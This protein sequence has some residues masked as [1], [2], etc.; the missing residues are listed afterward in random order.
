MS[1]K[2]IIVKKS[3]RKY[4][5][6]YTILFAFMACIIYIYFI[7][8]NRSFVWHMDGLTQHLPALTYLGGWL[9]QI[10]KNIFVNHSF[11]IPM[12]D[13]SIGYGSDIITTLHY[14]AL[15]DP[16]NIFAI[17]VPA[18]K[19]E[20]LYNILI[21]VRLYLAGI[22]FS[23][24]C[25]SRGK[26]NFAILV[27][28][29]IYVFC[30]YG[31]SVSVRHPYFI[32]PMIYF[33]ILLIGIEKIFK[34]QKPYLFIIATAV[35]AI[36]NFYFFYMLA[37]LIFLYAVFRYV[38]LFKKIE[39]KE[40]LKWVM[41]FSGYFLIGSCIAMII[42]LPNAMLVVGSARY[43]AAKTI[44]LLYLEQQYYNTFLSFISAKHTS[45]YTHLNFST[46]ALVSI[47]VLFTQKKDKLA[48][49]IGLLLTTIFYLFP[50]FGFLFNGFSSSQ[51]R[52]I[53]GYAL[54][55]AFISVDMIPKFFELNKKDKK[56]IFIFTILYT[57]LYLFITS[58][59][60]V[61]CYKCVCSALGILVINVILI[62]MI[63][64]V[65]KSK[66]FIQILIL[67]ITCIGIG[68][69]AYFIFSENQENY[70][71]EFKESGKAYN[72]I[73]NSPSSLVKNIKDDSVFRYDQDKG[74]KLVYNSSVLENLFGVGYRFS[75]ADGNI[76]KFY[77][78]NFI[79]TPRDYS[80]ST[81]DN[82]TI[83]DTLA[84]VKYFI[85]KNNRTKDLPYGYK[86]LVTS[87]VANKKGYQV[88]TTDNYL[89]L[90]YT[91]ENYISKE[92][93]DSLSVTQKQ[94]AF[95]QGVVLDKKINNMK[96]SELSFTDKKVDYTITPDKN[97]K[98]IG[99]KI[100]TSKKNSTVTLNF[101]GL[102]NSETYLVLNKI[103]VSKEMISGKYKI[104]VE[105]ENENKVVELLTERERAYCGR[106]SFL[107][108]LNYN[109]KESNQ[110]K[111]TFLKQG[112]YSFEELAVVCQPMNGFEQAVKKLK[113]DTL[114]SIKID[115]N[116][117][118]GTI[119]L[120]RSKFLVLSIPYSKGW[121]V[122]VDG[123]KQEVLKANSMY[124][125]TFLEPGEHNVVFRYH[126]PY[127]KISASI[128]IMGTLAFI[129]VFIYHKKREK[130]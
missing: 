60:S 58:R 84:S 88:Y 44:P 64:N 37:I 29:I 51:N 23:I 86:K 18:A 27:G 109:Q 24:Y 122:Y 55:V 121:T 20:Y 35:S 4:F 67:G 103:G 5:I 128:S 31:M 105:G 8:K 59:L 102:K 42:F 98:I 32:N 3:A 115:T 2:D 70:V 119:T 1:N 73:M 123:K 65:L 97:T 85:I 11:V 106:D 82:R 72:Q 45:A 76:S 120:E 129:I 126:T 90:G 12:W 47:F 101:K 17:F 66:R 30:G 75:M 38:I 127:L 83:L 13:M 74:N 9:R 117:I 116:K 19:M 40:L 93:Y 110:I 7:L 36:S 87:E 48:L 15:G 95:L 130:E 34:K 61:D 89:P 57:G 21:I 14:Y 46:M 92:T 79:N 41:K 99:N 96:E 63:G 78:E 113:E 80:Y 69:N 81:L 62:L 118:S 68:I 52:W 114:N 6:S 54:L 50:F 53:W 25:R 16:L 100:I 26:D 39:I 49:K 28:A 91:Y 125:G 10:F 104:K 33:P 56:I 107:C 71:S 22:T 94:W 112:E 111:M 108:N 43:G 124:L 77:E